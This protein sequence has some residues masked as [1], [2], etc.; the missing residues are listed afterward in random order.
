MADRY[1]VGGSGT[2]DTTSTANWSSTNGG[3]GGASA[4]NINDVAFFNANSGAGTITLG[5]NVSVFRVNWTGY[6]GTFDPSDYVI[7]C[8]GDGATSLWIAGSTAIFSPTPTVNFT[9]PGANNRT[10]TFGSNINRVCNVNITAGTGTFNFSGTTLVNNL[11]FTGFAGELAGNS[12]RISGYLVLSV[13]MVIAAN[14]TSL[15]FSD[16][17]TKTI[18]TNG[19][20][21][22][23]PILFSAAASGG[24]WNFQ[25]AV[26]MAPARQFRVN[27]GTVNF[28]AGTTNSS[29]E[30]VFVG[31]SAAGRQVGVGS[32]TPGAQATI[33][34]PN[35][36]VNAA[37]VTIQDSNATGGAVWTAY[38]DLGNVDAGNND[39]WDFS[40]SPTQQSF[41]YPYNFRSFTRLR[42]F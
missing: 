32:T 7:N 8:V 14:T 35:G 29:D 27:A 10:A 37:F 15:T 16:L 20:V 12:V 39:G 34:Q 3:A 5:E 24:V 13:G 9:Y 42:R 4:P 26:T 33:S 21:I 2:W 28:K 23:R 31:T 36:E 25:D 1:W 6:T 17:G 18:T 30:F 19:V 41:E 22:D 11:D 38:V 40:L